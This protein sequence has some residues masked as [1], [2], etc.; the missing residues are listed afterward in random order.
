[1][2]MEKNGAISSNTPGCKNNCGC[3]KQAEDLVQGEL[4]PESIKQA[5]AIDGDL[6]KQAVDAVRQ[7]SKPSR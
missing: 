3:A 7:C 4:F 6:T 5:D 2:S 1:M